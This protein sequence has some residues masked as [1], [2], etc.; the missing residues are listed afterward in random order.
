MKTK[1]KYKIQIVKDK[2]DENE[3]LWLEEDLMRHYGE[4]LVNW[5]NLGIESDLELNTQYWDM[6][7]ENERLL[8][9]IL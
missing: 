4:Q 2:V 1:G 6:R 3:A 8:A 7:K 9:F 5:A